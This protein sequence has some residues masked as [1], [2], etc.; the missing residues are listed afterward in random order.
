MWEI[1]LKQKKKNILLLSIPSGTGYS[2][3]LWSL[4]YWR[5]WKPDWALPWAICS[6]RYYFEQ[7]S[8]SESIPED[9]S[10]LSNSVILWICDNEYLPRNFIS[11]LLLKRAGWL[12]FWSKERP[13]ARFISTCYFLV[14]TAILTNRAAWTLLNNPAICSSDSEQITENNCFGRNICVAIEGELAEE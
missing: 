12:Q 1:L 5:H 7:W 8:W 13:I 2:K 10:N 14:A 11:E 3:A 9:P 6:S 4:L